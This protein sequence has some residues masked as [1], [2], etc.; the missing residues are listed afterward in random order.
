LHLKIVMKCTNK[1]R[2]SARLSTDTKTLKL[3][4]LLLN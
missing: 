1:K 2:V 3:F 4:I